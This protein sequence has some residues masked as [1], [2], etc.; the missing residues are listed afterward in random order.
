LETDAEGEDEKFNLG[1][2]GAAD[3]FVEMAPY[4]GEC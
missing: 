1:E 4:A 3:I 2:T